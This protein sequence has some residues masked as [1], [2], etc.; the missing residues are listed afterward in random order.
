MKDQQLKTQKEKDQQEISL[1]NQIEMLQYK[2]L[3]GERAGS[4]AAATDSS[5]T[6]AQLLKLCQGDVQDISKRLQGITLAQDSTE[7]SLREQWLEQGRMMNQLR[8]EHER[9]SFERAQEAEDRI[10]DV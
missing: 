4:M 1:N 6:F 2:L 7:D 8:Q 5:E 10:D 9:Q 3:S